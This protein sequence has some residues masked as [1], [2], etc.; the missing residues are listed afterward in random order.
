MFNEIKIIDWIPTYKVDEYISK[1]KDIYIHNI[2]E[3][4]PTDMFNE[5][6][7]YIIDNNDIFAFDNQRNIKDGIYWD[8][9]LIEYENKDLRNKDKQLMDDNIEFINVIK[10]KT[11]E[12]NKQ[13]AE[14]VWDFELNSKYYLII[15]PYN[16]FTEETSSKKWIYRWIIVNPSL[17]YSDFKDG[18]N[19]QRKIQDSTNAIMEYV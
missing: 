2:P 16:P 7:K 5:L 8:Y 9:I 12:W 19:T 15:S 17:Y 6:V 10:T 13:I 4:T 11:L 3:G 1:D 14:P 18:N